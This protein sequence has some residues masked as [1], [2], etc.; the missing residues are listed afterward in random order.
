VQAE[1]I[2]RQYPAGRHPAA[3]ALTARHSGAAYAH[4]IRDHDALEAEATP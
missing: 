1:L 3:D 2:S 4:Y